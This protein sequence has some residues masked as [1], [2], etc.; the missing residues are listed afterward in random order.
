MSPTQFRFY[1]NR[2]YR[3]YAC[4]LK[5]PTHHSSILVQNSYF[6]ECTLLCNIIRK[7]IDIGFHQDMTW[8]RQIF[9]WQQR[10]STQGPT[11]CNIVKYYKYVCNTHRYCSLDS[12]ARK[13][14]VRTDTDPCAIKL[15]EDVLAGNQAF[16]RT[17]VVSV[18][19][20]CVR[21][22]MYVRCCQR[23]RRWGKNRT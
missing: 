4:S 15:K 1:V 10:R 2:V 14:L 9:H 22:C 19:M 3:A 13:N 7:R 21:V 18:P 20:C 11:N 23:C 17:Y 12:L 8:S 16:L 5:L 6:Y